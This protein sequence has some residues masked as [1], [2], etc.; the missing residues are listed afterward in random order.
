MTTVTGRQT[1][2]CC[3]PCNPRPDNHPKL[4]SLVEL[5]RVRPVAWRGGE[6][7]SGVTHPEGRH[8][9]SHAE[10]PDAFL[11]GGDSRLLY[12]FPAADA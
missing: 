11:T 8:R 9:I 2:E 1:Q 5:H 6:N 10:N 7:A 4:D 3:Q 12:G